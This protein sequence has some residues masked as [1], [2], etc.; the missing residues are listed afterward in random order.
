[1]AWPRIGV[2]P[3]DA[4]WRFGLKISPAVRKLRA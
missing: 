4:S 1:M 2:Y 3:I